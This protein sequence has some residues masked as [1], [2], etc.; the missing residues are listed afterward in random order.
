MI[1]QFKYST[2]SLT[3]ILKLGGIVLLISL[4]SCKNKNPEQKEYDL[5]LSSLKYKSYKTLSENTIPP[6][7]LLF[8]TTGHTDEPEISEGILRLLLGY[9]WIAG[10]RPEYAIAECNILKEFSKSNKAIKSS[11]HFLAALA[12][13]E[14][15]W[16]SLAS[17]ESEKGFSLIIKTPISIKEQINSGCW[18]LQEAAVLQM[19]LGTLYV[20]QENYQNAKL[21]FTDFNNSFILEWPYKLADAMADFKDKN[22]KNGLKKINFISKN[23][24]TPDTLKKTLI[25]IL[26]KTKIKPDSIAPDKLWTKLTSFALY[27]E[28]EKNDTFKINKMAFL[29]EI[30]REKLKIE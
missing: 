28:I 8:N 14:K 26:S 18:N 23:K 27:N 13:Y 11:S 2:F 12:M 10:D 19:I 15:N 24:N 21:R 16:K 17:N 1:V 5:M 4:F 22:I 3:N 7:I 9:S 6:L 29:L 30:L 20:Y 25:E